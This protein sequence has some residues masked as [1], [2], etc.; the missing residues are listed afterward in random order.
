MGRQFFSG[1]TLEQALMVAARHYGIEPERVSYTLRDKKH[2]F[3]NIRRRVVIEVDPLAPEKRFVEL[4]GSPAERETASRFSASVA[5][6]GEKPQPIED[7]PDRSLSSGDSHLDRETSGVEQHLHALDE[8]FENACNGTEKREE[9]AF[10][11]AVQ[12]TGALAGM[13][14]EKAAVIERDGVYEVEISGAESQHLAANEGLLLRA[15]E[16]LLPRLV[17]GFLGHGLPCKVDS[18]GFRSARELDLREQAGSLAERVRLLG[19]AQELEPMD[20]ADRRTVHLTLADDPT[21]RTESEG[22]GFL[23]R[24]RIMPA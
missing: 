8:E 5:E 18:E 23:K 9:A 7:S 12:E 13:K 11:K 4:A 21:V 3:V 20:P 6:V 19:E 2:G 17:R 10:L 15:I 14:F 1:N 24:V 16:H 22:R